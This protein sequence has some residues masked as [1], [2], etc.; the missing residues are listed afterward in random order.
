M[1]KEV[2]SVC[3]KTFESSSLRTNVDI[4]CFQCPICGKWYCSDCAS[5]NYTSIDIEDFDYQ[6]VCDDCITKELSRLI[7]KAEY[8]QRAVEQAQAKSYQACEKLKN[9]IKVQSKLKGDK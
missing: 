9:Y 6:V 8:A 3:N 2:C 4:G 7:D 5:S 1:S